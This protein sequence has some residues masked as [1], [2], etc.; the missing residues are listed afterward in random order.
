MKF[1]S[2]F[3]RSVAASIAGVLVLAGLLHWLIVTDAQQERAVEKQGGRVKRDWTRL[4][5]PIIEVDLGI[6]VR[7]TF[8][9]RKGRPEPAVDLTA[10]EG[11]TSLRALNLSGSGVTSEDL[12]RFSH[13][14]NV[15]YLDL[16]SCRN[17]TAGGQ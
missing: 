15:E 4:G 16:Q 3:W 11:L 9:F 8:W 5:R 2:K 7:P 12:A 17:I 10:L 1:T 6:R 14:T 13:L